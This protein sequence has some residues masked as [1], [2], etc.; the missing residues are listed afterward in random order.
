M[1]V[2]AKGRGST[3]RRGKGS[4]FPTTETENLLLKIK[5]EE[6]REKPELELGGILRF[7]PN[8]HLH[9][10]DVLRTEQSINRNKL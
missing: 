7:E 6:Q 10:R 4:A 8:V 1:C 2:R 9:C 5:Q 3:L